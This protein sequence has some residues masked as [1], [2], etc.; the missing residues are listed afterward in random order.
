MVGSKLATEGAGGRVC[1]CCGTSAASRSIPACW[2]HWN[3][4][5]GELRSSIVISYGRGELTAYAEHLL[6]AVKVWRLA[7]VWRT[8]D[9]KAAPLTAPVAKAEP[10]ARVE[11]RVISLLER[12]LK[13]AVQTPERSVPSPAVKFT[14]RPAK[15]KV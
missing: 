13:F 1:L 10:V 3:M 5:P 11:R 12:R 4:L 6:A 8:K 15:R 14:E 9:K 2:Q 7:G